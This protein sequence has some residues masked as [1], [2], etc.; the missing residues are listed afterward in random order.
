MT[1]RQEFQKSENVNLSSKDRACMVSQPDKILTSLDP[2]S[3]NFNFE[4]CAKEVRQQMLIALQE[5][6]SSS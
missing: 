1:S 4:L 3:D 6:A 5:R 2:K